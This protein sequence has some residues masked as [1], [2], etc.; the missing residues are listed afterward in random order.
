MVVSGTDW[1]VHHDSCMHS[2]SKISH[3]VLRMAACFRPDAVARALCS[4]RGIHFRDAVHWL[5]GLLSRRSPARRDCRAGAIGVRNC[6]PARS[7]RLLVASICN[8]KDPGPS[9][10]C[11][12]IRGENASSIEILPYAHMPDLNREHPIG[13]FCSFHWKKLQVSAP[14]DV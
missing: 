12:S 5:V 9:S 1:Q 8:A 6:F 11:S 10:W 3:R 13:P 14:M 7:L 4:P 2:S